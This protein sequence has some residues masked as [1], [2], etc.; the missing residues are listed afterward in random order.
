MY[1]GGGGAT[2]ADGANLF[3]QLAQDPKKLEAGMPKLEHNLCFNVFNVSLRQVN[4][5]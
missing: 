4:M 5:W 2:M 3:A 1:I